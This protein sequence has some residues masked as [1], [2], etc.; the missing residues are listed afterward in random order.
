MS[1][2][3]MQILV[4]LGLLLTVLSLPAM[5]IYITFD[6]LRKLYTKPKKPIQKPEH[7]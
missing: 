3:L 6:D 5:A 7:P 4:Y 1:N 2:N